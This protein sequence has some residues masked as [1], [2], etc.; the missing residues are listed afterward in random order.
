MTP[1]TDLGRAGL[2]IEAEPSAGRLRTPFRARLASCQRA[3]RA[4]VAAERPEIEPRTGVR[5]NIRL[6]RRSFDLRLGGRTD[7]S[8]TRDQSGRGPA[9]GRRARPRPADRARRD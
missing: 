2:T 8:G 7:P 3:R 4:D 9:S 6:D 1:A 5:L